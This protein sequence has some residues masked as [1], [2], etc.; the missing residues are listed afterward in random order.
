M[1]FIIPISRKRAILDFMA[2]TV[3]K[4]YYLIIAVKFYCPRIKNISTVQQSPA[5]YL[6]CD[7]HLLAHPLHVD[8]FLFTFCHFVFTNMFLELRFLYRIVS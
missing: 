8:G 1:G 3:L 7:N 6:Y 5:R 2:Q 4:F